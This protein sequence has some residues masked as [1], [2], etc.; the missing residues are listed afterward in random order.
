MNSS[1]LWFIASCSPLKV[2]RHYGGI[3]RLHLQGRRISQARKQHEAG[4][5]LFSCSAYW[6]LKMEATRSS[7]TSVDF[8]QATRC[9]IPEDKLL[10]RFVSLTY[11]SL[12]LSTGCPES[13]VGILVCFSYQM[14]LSTERSGYFVLK[15]VGRRNISKWVFRFVWRWILIL[16]SSDVKVWYS[17]K[18]KNKT[19]S[20]ASVRQRTIPTERPTLVGEVGA[21]FSG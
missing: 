5:K 9:V 19:N 7:E 18:Q 10:K 6:T 16:E 3:C 8:Q 20:G 15:N 11:Y 21:N 14:T 13:S 2:N 12:L 1:I 17:G 4:S